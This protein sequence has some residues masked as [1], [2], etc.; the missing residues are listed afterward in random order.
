MLIQEIWVT[1]GLPTGSRVI[2]TRNREGDTGLLCR[3]SRVRTDVGSAISHLLTGT[4]C[5]GV[6]ARTKALPTGSKSRS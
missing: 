6:R 2:A 5:R 1:C 4:Q 3:C